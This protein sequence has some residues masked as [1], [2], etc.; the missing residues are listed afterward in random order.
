[1]HQLKGTTNSRYPHPPARRSTSGAVTLVDSPIPERDEIQTS[2]KVES[3]KSADREPE[4]SKT[5]E[6]LGYGS[7]PYKNFVDT[8]SLPST[9]GTAIAASAAFTVLC[10]DSIMGENS[11]EI[12]ARSREMVIILAWSAGLFAIATA[13][14]ICLQALYSSPSFCKIIRSKL[15]YK[16]ELRTKFKGWQDLGDV[17]RYMIA[18]IAVTGAYLAIILHLV[19][20]VLIIG[21]FKPYAPALIAQL[22][23]GLIFVLGFVGWGIS[24]ALEQREVQEIW[25]KWLKWLRLTRER[26]QL[27]QSVK[28]EDSA[29]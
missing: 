24:V 16:R 28:P 15:H 18:Y 2:E 4:M 17:L 29:V 25:K 5:E 22:V 6:D 27:S 8:L 9:I 26:S 3:R 12:K 14:T 11:E 1:M 13:I 23:M 21:I 10:A 20:T 7:V 19:A